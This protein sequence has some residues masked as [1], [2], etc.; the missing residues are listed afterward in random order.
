MKK[1]HLLGLAII[2]LFG[3]ARFNF[4]QKLTEEHRAAFFHGATLD[5]S[6]RQQ[7][8]QTAFLAALGGFRAVVADLLWI[9]GHIAWER[10]EWGRMALLFNNVTTLQPR[11]L[12]FWDIYAWHMGYNASLA[13]INDIH[14]ADPELRKKTQH[15]YIK[16][17]EDIY[18]RG[19]KNN[20]DK[21]YLYEM[22]AK[23][24]DD[25]PVY[26]DKNEEHLKAYEYFTKAASF[27]NAPVFEK[28]MAAY[29]LSYVPGREQEAYDLLVKYYNMGNKEHLPTLLLRLKYLQDKLN[30]P[31]AQKIQF[32]PDELQELKKLEDK[33]NIPPAREDYNPEEK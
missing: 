5:L 7:L 27:P 18:L 14:Q 23:L 25:K 32:P 2:L 20:P 24:Y 13:A 4:E 17:A 31:P 21:Y 1:V 12:T 26:A 6:L 11:N 8:G 16:A 10:T 30:I 28:R 29:D 3:A 22:L 9:E 19:I 33:V 15:Q